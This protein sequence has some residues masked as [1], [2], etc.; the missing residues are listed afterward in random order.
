M[1]NCLQ[2]KKANRNKKYVLCALLILLTS[3]FALAAVK[4][5]YIG[6]ETKER[7]KSRYLSSV[8]EFSD[9][10]FVKPSE[11]ETDNGTKMNNYDEGNSKNA[12]IG[13]GT[14][15]FSQETK[16]NVKVLMKD[17]SVCQ[18][19]L[20]EYVAGC[21]LGE[22]S[23][24]FAPQALMA[25]CVAVRTFT[26]RQMT[27]GKSKHKNADICADFNCCQ[28]FVYPESMSISRE[29][30][31]KLYDAVSA[32][33]GTVMIYNGEPIEAVYHSSSGYN[34]LDS[35]DVWG[36]KVEYLRSVKAPEGEAKISSTGYGHRVGL[37][38][39]GANILA[40]DGMSYIE[41]LKYYYSGISFAFI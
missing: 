16:R 1:Q 36:G 11:Q 25:Q 17:G 2:S 6:S 27:C 19:P 32:T 3:V 22:M 14:A 31:K 35:E 8:I 41:I 18:M 29:N 39:H 12:Y 34:T 23:L 33:S 38:Q 24:S 5:I 28:N 15:D 20:E 10:G 21:V 7:G 13:N 4:Y 30:L 37:S 26:V 40:Q 9:D